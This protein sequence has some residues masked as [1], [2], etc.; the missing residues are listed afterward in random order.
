M[1]I[2]AHESSNVARCSSSSG[3]AK[4]FAEFLTVVSAELMHPCGAFV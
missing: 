1:M 4:Q 2:V 3:Q